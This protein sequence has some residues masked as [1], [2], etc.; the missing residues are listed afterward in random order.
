MRVL[1]TNDDGVEAPGLHALASAL[2]H[3]GHDVI[4][5]APSGERSGSGA[6]IGRLHR[7]GPIA[8]KQVEWADLPGVVVHA[9]DAPP[10]ATVYAGC[11][12]AFGAGPDVVASGVNAGLNYGHLVLHSGTVGAALTAKVLGCSAVAV[13]LGWGDE[14]QEWATA[15]TVA[16]DA[17]E[18][19]GTQAG[20]PMVVNLNVP[21]IPISELR[22]IR[23]ARLSPFNECWN[24]STSPGELHL[25]YAGHAEEPAAD[26]DYAIV[27]SGYAAVTLLD[28]VA[29]VPGTAD[30]AARAMNRAL[31]T[32]VLRRGVA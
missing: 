16:A 28:G 25:E 31:D 18:W 29:V 20:A 24:A 9:L 22:G 30:S 12:G 27:R 26:S 19:L 10:A 6:A 11:V 4:V 2:H 5:V 13:S 3:A 8:W 21:N 14:V 1:V 17:V 15:A 23:S 7:A 32:R